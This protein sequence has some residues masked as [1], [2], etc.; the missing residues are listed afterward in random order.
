CKALVESLE[1]H[2]IGSIQRSAPVKAPGI[3]GGVVIPA[4]IAV[5]TYFPG[6]EFNGAV[7]LDPGDIRFVE[8]IRGFLIKRIAGEA[9]IVIGFQVFDDISQYI[10]V[11]QTF[12]IL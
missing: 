5:E 8:P 1:L 10:T 9:D 4:Q 2:E 3:D 11:M 7:R 12:R 6:M